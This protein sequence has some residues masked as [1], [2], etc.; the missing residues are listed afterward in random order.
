MVFGN[1][2]IYYM[3]VHLRVRHLV[4]KNEDRS[5]SQVCPFQEA[6]GIQ[7]TLVAKDHKFYDR[8]ATLS[9]QFSGRL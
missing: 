9:A 4:H 3:D 8:I 6:T 1:L 5:Q 7:G 2:Y